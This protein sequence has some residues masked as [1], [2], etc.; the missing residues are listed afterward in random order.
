MV[1][2]FSFMIFMLLN[3]AL[4]KYQLMS[5]ARLG[6]AEDVLSLSLALFYFFTVEQCHAT[7]L[8]SASHKVSALNYSD[9]CLEKL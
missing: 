1:K 6:K 9:T 8:L 5:S 2:S 4:F 3:K 7:A